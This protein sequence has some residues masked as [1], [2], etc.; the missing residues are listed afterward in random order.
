MNILM[1]LLIAFV[2]IAIGWLCRWLYAK[3]KLTSV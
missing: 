1:Y 2:G 3:F